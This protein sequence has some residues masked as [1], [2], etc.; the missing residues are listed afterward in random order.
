MWMAAPAPHGYVSTR[1]KEADPLSDPRDG[2]HHGPWSHPP[3]P[4]IPAI[5]PPQPRRLRLTRGLAIWLGVV[6]LG[7]ALYLGLQLVFPGQLDRNDQVGALQMLGWLALVSSGLV[8]ARRLRFGELVR[9]IA[10]WGAIAGAA[11]LAYSFRDEAAAVFQ[12]VRGELIPA[13]AVASGDHAMTVTAAD[14]GGFYVMGQVN[15]A[16]VRFAID[17]GANGV[18]LSPADAAR[19]GV[20]VDTLKFASPSETAN[21]VGYV[22]PVTLASLD[23]GQI[24]LTGVPAAVDK[25][26]MTTSLLGMAFLKRLDSFE[27]KGDRLTLKWR[28]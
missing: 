1:P 22:A 20:D 2:P 12:R 11:I 25:A 13:M 18:V 24:K 15:G 26:P 23:V 4:P 8:F 6:G 10:I 17:T 14:D 7:I 9:S 5:A 27:V 16:A 3:E 28:G 21:G 19:A